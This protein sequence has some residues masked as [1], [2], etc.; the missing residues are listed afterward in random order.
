[1]T[2][3]KTQKEPAARE[4]Q[5]APSM[6]KALPTPKP[7]AVVFD[8]PGNVKINLTS[9]SGRLYVI[10]SREVFNIAAEDVDWFLLAWDW[11]HRQHLCLAADYEAKHQ[12]HDEKE[13]LGYP[14]KAPSPAPTPLPVPEL[15][16]PPED[17]PAEEPVPDFSGEE[18]DTEARNE[19]PES[20]EHESDIAKGDDEA[21]ATA[22]ESEE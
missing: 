8:A 6:P 20:G 11:K 17:R 9:P 5:K 22:A 7:V 13:G 12:Y 15:P 10:K 16:D 1:M 4:T 2:R 19:Q 21:C 18:A 14:P 3:R